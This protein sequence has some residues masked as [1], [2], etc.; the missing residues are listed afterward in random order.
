[1]ATFGGATLTDTGVIGQDTINAAD[2]KIGFGNLIT[3]IHAGDL[4]KDTAERPSN[5]R[6]R[7]PTP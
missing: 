4:P 2:P 7:L 5:R 1:M 3:N 6:R